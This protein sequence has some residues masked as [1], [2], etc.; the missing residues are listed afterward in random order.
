MKRHTGLSSV[1]ILVVFMWGCVQNPSLNT[2]PKP[3]SDQELAWQ[4]L[5][6]FFDHLH[7]GKYQEAA[8]LY[9]GEYETMIAQNPDLGSDRSRC[10]LQ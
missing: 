4:T 5:Y 10:P 2:T 1:T 3:S 6:R 9:G 8:S 7:D